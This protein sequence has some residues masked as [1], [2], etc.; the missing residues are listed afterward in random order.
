MLTG[1]GRLAHR[2]R[3]VNL[4]LNGLYWSAH[5]DWLGPACWCAPGAALSDASRFFDKNWQSG[6]RSRCRFANEGFLWQIWDAEISMGSSL[7]G[8]ALVNTHRV[9]NCN[10]TLIGS[11]DTDVDSQL[12]CD[13]PASAA[14][15]YN[16]LRKHSPFFRRLF[17]DRLQSHF[18]NGRVLSRPQME[19]RIARL[20][21]QLNMPMGAESARWGGAN[22]GNP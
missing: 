19:A 21:E 8:T 12:T 14:E 11:P 10:H 2:G 20:R 6:R 15:I 1:R 13:V 4:Y 9:T 17:A 3:Y 7:T 18:F 22:F 16:A 5:N